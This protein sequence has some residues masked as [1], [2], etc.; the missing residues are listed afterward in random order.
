[1]AG[2]SRRES[3]GLPQHVRIGE[4]VK[5]ERER[6]GLSQTD[7]AE[8]LGV[9]PTIVGRIEKGD[10]VLSLERAAALAQLFRCPLNRF[11]TVV[12]A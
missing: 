4:A 3:R 7:V 5:R 6:A 8:H 1:M 10:I 12:A 9:D 11:A 2:M